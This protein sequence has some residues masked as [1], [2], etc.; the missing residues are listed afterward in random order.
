MPHCLILALLLFQNPSLD[1]ASPKERQAAVEQLAVL[2][3]RDAIP[4][5]GEALKKES[6]SDIRASIIAA[7]GRIRDRDAIPFLTDSLR[8]DLEKNV[9]LQAIDSLLRLYIPIEDSGPLHTLFG[10]V[11]SVFF[12]PNPP[13][14]GPE[15]QVDAATKQALAAAMQKDFDDDVRALAARAL[16]TLK[17][18]DQV[19]TLTATLEDPQN[20][21]HRDVRIEI[22]RTLALIR[23]PAAG[24]ALEKALRDPNKQI[25]LEAISAVGLVNDT[26]ARPTL[27][28]FFRND[29]D[30]RIKSRSLE[31]LA[32]LRD[33]GSM[34]LFESLLND[35]NDYYR[36]LAAEG[37][38]RLNYKADGWKDRFDQERKP[39]V[40]NALAFGLASSGQVDYINNLANALD[41]R[42]DY[43]AEAYLFE[44]GKFDGQMNELYRYLK[45]SNPKVRAGMA[46]VIGNIG[47]PTA[48][49]QIRPLTE[50]S[51]T[52]VVREAVA[53]LRKLNR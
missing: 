19:P 45:S 37:L 14:V 36:E 5:L 8:T 9:R 42:Q 47:D 12:E 25:V 3:N 2:G 7:F 16:G 18:K 6:K 20:R 38:A 24:P 44:L 15:V 35:K 49:A 50:D 23:D 1:S 51:D 10:K 53:A 26:A 34:P 43:Q 33:K 31:A 52:E 13:V 46:K 4:K 21:E 11:K 29:K 30:N 17:A 27:E 41:S 28:E 48:L 32:L 40:R 39:N 22:I